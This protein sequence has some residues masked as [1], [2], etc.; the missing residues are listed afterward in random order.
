MSVA[1]E[2]EKER[3]PRQNS[4]PAGPV[5]HHQA[6]IENA[7]VREES[8]DTGGAGKSAKGGCQLAGARRQEGRKGAGGCQQEP[9]ELT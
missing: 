1:I 6:Q 2:R 9:G 3:I 7:A 4:F 5:L 8:K